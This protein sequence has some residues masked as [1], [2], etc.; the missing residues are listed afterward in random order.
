M[1]ESNFPVEKLSCTYM[2]LW[3]S[4][5]RIASG[6]SEFEKADMF[7]RTAERV[8]AIGESAT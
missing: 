8:Y 1:F 6:F 5:K 4:F 2:V 3:N 7:L